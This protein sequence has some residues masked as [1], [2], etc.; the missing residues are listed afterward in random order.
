[1][2][3]LKPFTPAGKIE[4]PKCLGGWMELK[5]YGIDEEEYIEVTCGACGYSWNMETADARKV[6]V[7]LECK[8][9]IAVTGSKVTLVDEKPALTLLKENEEVLKDGIAKIGDDVKEVMD[10]ATIKEKERLGAIVRKNAEDEDTKE[11]PV[12]KGFR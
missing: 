2:K 10:E 3:D 5:V 4:C 1:M 12:D 8:D 7:I 9:E 11:A 6:K